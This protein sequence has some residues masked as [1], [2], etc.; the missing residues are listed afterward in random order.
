LLVVAEAALATR[1]HWQR[2]EPG[3]RRRLRELVGK[4]RGRL[5]NL[6]RE[7]RTE[8]RR[9][10]REID[11]RALARDLAEVASPVRLPGRR[12]RRR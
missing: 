12:R 9:L 11:A 8:L 1:K 2:L 5:S 6:T 7:D 10:V 3:T 4:S